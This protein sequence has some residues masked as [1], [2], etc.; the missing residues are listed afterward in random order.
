MSEKF[1]THHV[2]CFDGGIDIFA[3]NAD[4]HAHEHVLRTFNDFS[5]DLEQVASLEGLEAEVLNEDN[6]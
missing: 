4:G 1:F 2:V 3:V 5:V 6:V